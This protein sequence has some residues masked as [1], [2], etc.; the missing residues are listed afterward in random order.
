MAYRY[1]VSPLLTLLGFSTF[2]IAEVKTRTIEYLVDGVTCEGYFAW[3]DAVTAPRPGILVLHEWKGL[4]DYARDRTEALARLGYVA[5]AADMYGKD[6]RP[7]TREEAMTESGRL[8]NDRALVRRRAN[9]SLELLK[10]K[11]SV[12]SSRL[13]AIGYCFG[14][15][16]ALELARS[17]A[18]LKGVVSFHGSLDT[19]DLVS[20]GQVKAKLLVL[21]GAADPAVPPDKVRA[22]E[23]EMTAAGVD[24]QLV[25]YGGAVHAFTN[26]NAGNNPSTGAAYDPKAAA[27]S[28]KAM[29]TFFDE[30]FSGR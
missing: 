22:F 6:I 15:M 1:I 7:K 30:L 24:W 20:A 18:E 5:F 13:A 14:G 17:G 29:Q 19:P 9:A 27:R 12:D 11:S 10:S 23:S 8:R 28:W 25:S 4:E 16:C 26:P 3:D 21:H 2:T